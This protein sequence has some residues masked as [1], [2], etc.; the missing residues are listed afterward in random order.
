MFAQYHQDQM[1]GSL[2]QSLEHFAPRPP[3][4]QE[5]EAPQMPVMVPDK[6]QEEPR[7]TEEDD[8]A[9]CRSNTLAQKEHDRRVAEKNRLR[10]AKFNKK[11]K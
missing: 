11:N 3:Q 2:A 10:K 7:R 9:Y 8:R 1:L 6:R 4:P 5:P